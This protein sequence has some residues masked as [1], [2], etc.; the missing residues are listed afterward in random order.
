MAVKSA[1]RGKMG[2]VKVKLALTNAYDEEMARRGLIKRNAIRR[3]E[4]DAI[5]DTGATRLVLPGPI[6]RQ[7][8]LRVLGQVTVRYADDRNAVRDLVG[9]VVVKVMGRRTQVDA[10]IEPHKT[11][12]LLGQIP[13]EA[14]DF[15]V[16]PLGQRLLPNPDFP[17][18][19]LS[20]MQ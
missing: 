10:I 1:K 9:I 16:D 18:L 20:E 8:G 4:V 14:L 15:H 2:Q 5:V 11:Y 12:A 19:P 13:L 3:A 6:A 7:L 17:D